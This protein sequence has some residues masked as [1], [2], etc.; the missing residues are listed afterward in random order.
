MTGSSRA[1]V[2]LALAAT[3]CAAAAPS[4][5]ADPAF[6]LWLVENER[7][8]IEIGPCGVEACGRIAWMSEPSAPDGTPKID[9]FNPDPA[10]RGAPLCGLLLM[11]GLDRMGP[12]RWTGGEI[13]DSRDGSVWSVELTAKGPRILEVRGYI[14]IS[15]LGRSQT[16]TRTANARGGCALSEAAPRGAGRADGV[17]PAKSPENR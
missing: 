11:N 4:A 14:G 13:Y 16:W 5:G 6:G 17:T 10:L 3:L 9:L 15:L 1:V 7:A 8:I 12:G 2:P